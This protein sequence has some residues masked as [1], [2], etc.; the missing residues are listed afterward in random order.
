[1]VRHFMVQRREN[2]SLATCTLSTSSKFH[3]LWINW[4]VGCSSSHTL[5]GAWNFNLL[6]KR[7]ESHKF[8]PPTSFKLDLT[9]SPTNG[10]CSCFVTWI[11]IWAHFGGQMS[12]HQSLYL[13]K[14]WCASASSK[15]CNL[16]IFLTIMAPISVP[17]YNNNKQVYR[18][19]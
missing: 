15:Q 19:S 14:T 3:H 8:L 4:I 16:E 18:K 13:K 2:S 9:D 12:K 6:E 17:K 5:A 7:L 11:E 1:M 10:V